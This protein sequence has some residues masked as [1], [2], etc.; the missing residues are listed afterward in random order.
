MKNLTELLPDHINLKSDFM[1][2]D[3]K[4][5]EAEII[6]KNIVV[7]QKKINPKQW[8]PFSFKEY[9]ELC[10]HEVGDSEKKVLEAMV[11]GG[12]PVWNTSTYLEPGYLGKNEDHYHVTSKFLKVISKF[13]KMEVV[14]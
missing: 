4:N 11:N 7:I 14:F 13:L 8:T 1:G 2:S 6:A 5:R 12:K 9:S 10:D 3:F